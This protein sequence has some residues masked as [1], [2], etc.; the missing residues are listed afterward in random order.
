MSVSDLKKRKDIAWVDESILKIGEFGPPA[1][2]ETGF[3]YKW[4]NFKRGFTWGKTNLIEIIFVIGFMLTSIVMA[5]FSYLH[6]LMKPGTKP[7]GFLLT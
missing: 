7:L 3:S 4:H 2:D 1:Y 5:Q 6:H